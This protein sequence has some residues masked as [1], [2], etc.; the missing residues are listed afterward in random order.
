VGEKHAGMKRPGK[1]LPSFIRAWLYGDSSV[2]RA[3]ISTDQRPTAKH[4]P[5]P[6]HCR[7][8]RK[9]NDLLFSDQE[10]ADMDDGL[11]A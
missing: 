4:E 7:F 5:T 2:I 11:T 3:I 6:S 8:F 1:G 10:P 9:A